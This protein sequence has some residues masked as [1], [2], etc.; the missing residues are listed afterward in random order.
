MVESLPLNGLIRSGTAKAVGK[1]GATGSTSG[2]SDALRPPAGRRPA[3][4]PGTL[5]TDTLSLSAEAVSVPAELK[6]G[7]PIN[8]A[9]VARIKEAIAGGKYP[10]NLDAIGNAMMQA[11]QDSIG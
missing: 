6:S 3:P 1:A 4:P 10:V 5:N 11:W 7:P 9:Q 8:S 2:A